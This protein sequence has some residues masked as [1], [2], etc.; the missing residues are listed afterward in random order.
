MAK[1]GLFYGSTEKPLQTFEGDYMKTERDSV[2]IFT[3][4]KEGHMMND[5][6]VSLKLDKGQFIKKLSD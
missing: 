2:K 6:V 5:E 4:A 1:F 3:Y